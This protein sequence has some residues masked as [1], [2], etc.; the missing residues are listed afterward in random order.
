MIARERGFSRARETDSPF[1]AWRYSCNRDFLFASSNV[2]NTRIINR[3]KSGFEDAIEILPGEKFRK[4]KHE[5]AE[6][7]SANKGFRAFLFVSSLYV[8][9][10]HISNG[11]S[12]LC[13]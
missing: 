7:Y 1:I 8:E 12:Y 6:I 9:I 2:G 11:T 10:F 5:V 13:V 4:L 3:R